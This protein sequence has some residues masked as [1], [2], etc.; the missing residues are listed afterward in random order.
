MTPN[1]QESSMRLS[2]AVYNKGEF[3][4]AEQNF[5]KAIDLWKKTKGDHEEYGVAPIRHVSIY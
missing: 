3:I 4:M 1:M 5:L 2:A